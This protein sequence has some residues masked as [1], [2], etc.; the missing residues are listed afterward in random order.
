MAAETIIFTCTIELVTHSQKLVASRKI[1][2]FILFCELQAGD[3]A[4]D[5]VFLNLHQVG[6][7]YSHSK[8][9]VEAS[10]VGNIDDHSRPIVLVDAS[11]KMAFDCRDAGNRAVF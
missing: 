5:Y 9:R 7:R 11:A 3:G 10:V 4:R 1:L 8:N 6:I 2:R